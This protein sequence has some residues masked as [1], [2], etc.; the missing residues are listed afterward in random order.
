MPFINPD[1]LIKNKK[2][3][4]ITVVFGRFQ[5]PTLG[6]KALFDAAVKKGLEEHS[7]VILVPTRTCEKKKTASV[8]LGQNIREQLKVSKDLCS[9]IRYPLKY[10]EKQLFIKT[11]YPE[12]IFPNYNFLE[13]PETK[14]EDLNLNVYLDL[15]TFLNKYAGY[16]ELYFIA[17]DDRVDSFNNDI[18][19][20]NIEGKRFKFDIFHGVTDIGEGK[21]VT[22]TV[23]ETD[24]ELSGTMVRFAAI[25]GLSKMFYESIKTYEGL[26]I[27]TTNNLMVILRNGLG[28]QKPLMDISED[29]EKK[30]LEH[31]LKYLHPVATKKTSGSDTTK[32]QKVMQGG[33]YFN[34]LWNILKV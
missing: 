18:Q 20:R 32:R 29:N 17:G 31:I 8:T 5:P 1:D 7:D 33:F 15:L 26:S 19:K 34:Y 9:T 14:F 27:E 22:T 13:I 6:H 16:K 28:I 4:K 23:L 25:L 24:I 11:L 10:H 30:M 21:R 2:S 3:D 12:S